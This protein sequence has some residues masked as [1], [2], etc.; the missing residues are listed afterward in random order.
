MQSRSRVHPRS[1][2]ADVRSLFRCGDG[3][4]ART[5]ASLHRC[6][7]Q[8]RDPCSRLQNT[9][10]YFTSEESINVW[11]GN[12]DGLKTYRRVTKCTSFMENSV[13]VVLAATKNL[14]LDADSF[15]TDFFLL[16]GICNEICMNISLI[17]QLFLQSTVDSNPITPGGRCPSG[18]S[19][20]H[21]ECF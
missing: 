1:R 3:G 20:K 14:F 21:S 6:C 18:C 19:H 10:T 12:K 2:L 7:L 9:Y 5:S 13:A 15:L 17:A 11:R 4:D 8:L 16:W